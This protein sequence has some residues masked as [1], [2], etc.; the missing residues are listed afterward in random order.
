M[1]AVLVGTDGPSRGRLVLLSETEVSVGR[2]E[3]NS[4][5]IDDAAVSKRH[6]TIRA[7][8][9]RFQLTDLDSRNGTFVNGVLVRQRLLEDN[10]E[11]RAGASVFLFRKRE[12]SEA[13]AASGGSSST[14]TLLRSDDSIFL[15]PRKLEETLPI[16]D[17]TAR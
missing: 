6:F 13:A 15:N 5:A 1:G 17:R 10:D 9:D 4:V 8:G 3:T 12:K 7:S 14:A 11:I 2:D 16:N